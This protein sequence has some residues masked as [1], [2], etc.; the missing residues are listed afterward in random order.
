MQESLR[1]LAKVIESEPD[2]DHVVMMAGEVL[3]ISPPM[4]A[5]FLVFL[6]RISEA[7]GR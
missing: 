1:E 5:E 3:M 6:Q 2:R 4:H 7:Q